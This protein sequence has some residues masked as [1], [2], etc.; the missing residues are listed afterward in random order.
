MSS[1]KQFD[2]MMWNGGSGSINL[3]SET[4]CRIDSVQCR[5]LDMREQMKRDVSQVYSV[6][7]IGCE[8]PYLSVLIFLTQG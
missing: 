8:G 6:T 4:R 3:C 5:R 1:L 2:E 7:Q